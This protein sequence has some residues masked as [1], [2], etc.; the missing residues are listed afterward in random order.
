MIDSG[1][2]GVG[3]ID[4]LFAQQHDLNLK[5]LPRHIDLFGFN[6][7]RIITG[8]ITHVVPLEL[9]YEG[10]K[11][12]ISL[13]V[14]TLGKHPIIL[15]LPWMRKHEV[16]FDWVNRKLRFTAQRC[17]NHQ[18]HARLSADTLDHRSA[19][20]RKTLS[21]QRRHDDWNYSYTRALTT[22][23]P[24]PEPTPESEPEP[25][26][27]DRS[28]AAKPSRH[29][30][31]R[32]K[33]S[34]KIDSEMDIYAIGAVPLTRL[35]RKPG[36]E[37]F[38]ITIADID[39]ALAPK[40][41]TNP[42]TKLPKEYYN[43]LDV[44]SRDRSNVLPE[45]RSYDHKI[46]LEPG[47]Q[48]G[49]GPL[50]SMSQNELKVLRKYLDEHL[51][52]GFIRASSSPAAAPVIFVKKPGGGLR[53]CVDYRTLN[54]ITVK[55]RYPI[56]LIQETL[57]R[58]S[59]AKYYT[60]LDIIAAFNRLRIAKGDEWLTAFRTR[61]GLFE[62]L[63]MPFGL[64]NAPST[65]QH[66]VNDV[67]RPYL[68]VFCTAYIDDI[69]IFSDNLSEHRKHV[70][71]VLQALRE[72]GLQ[73][74]IDKCEFHKTEVL[75]LGL[76]ITTNGIR[77]DPKKVEAVTNWESPSNVKDVRAFIGFANF[78]R[79]FIS[80]FSRLAAPLV[81]LTRKDVPF[82]F[83]SACEAA[84]QALKTAFTTAPIL[85]H[86]DPELPCVVEA[87]SSDYASGGVLS[88]NGLDGKLYPVAY[89]SH[90]LSPAECNYEIYD[91]ELLAIIRCFEQWRPELEG[92]AFP[93]KVLSDH[94]N[95]QYFC[96]TKQLSHRQ[97]RWSEY[98]SRFQFSIVYRPGAQGQKP[99]AL[100]R[101][102]QDQ[103]AQ[104]EAR[105]HRRQTL[106]RPE[107]FEEL[108]PIEAQ[109][110]GN[111]E[112]SADNLQPIDR[113]I[114]QLINDE[115]ENDEF[116]Q[117]ILG[118]LRNGTRRSK[119]ISLS[120]C[121]ARDNRLYFRNRLV[122]P[123][124]DELKVKLLRYVHDSPVGGHPGRT[125]TLEIL[126]RHYYWPQMYD[127]VR[128]FVG[129][130][131]TC[132]RSKASREAYS[133][134][135]RPLPV[136]SQR[137]KDISIDFVVDLPESDGCT[138]VMVVVD[139]LTKMVHYIPCSS[140][141]APDVAQLFLT[142]VWKLHGL[143][144]TII[145]DR[146]SQFVSAFWD[147]LMKRL[148]IEARLS[149]AFHPET[150]GQTE[151]KNAIMEQYF[152][153]YTSYLQDDWAKWAPLAEFTANNTISETTGIS[154]FLANYGQHPRLGFEPPTDIVRPV[155]QKQQ[156]DNVHKFV[157]DMKNIEAFIRDEMQ[158]AQA[159]YEEKANRKRSPAPAYQIGDF[160]WLDIRNLKTRRP[161]KKLD[162][163]NIG[164]FRVDKIVSPYAYRLE[165][166]NSIKIHPVFH[167]SLLRPAT[168]NEALPGQSQEAPP[169]VEIDG[170][171]EYQV[172]RIED[173]R[174][175]RRKRCHE[176]LVRW[177]GYDESS[178][179]PAD[180]VWDTSA[181][182]LFERDRPDKAVPR[183]TL[184]T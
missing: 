159:I 17:E 149:T 179:E 124:H 157:E 58:L 122:I 78:Y 46:Q 33:H 150:D 100:T 73:L 174:F 74:D 120:E 99:D 29:G 48:P 50:Y 170:E 61:Y 76:V 154:P 62:Y 44:F 63:V 56:P 91:K 136:P 117:E 80:D 87:D 57:N 85:R 143:P 94:K 42:R 12:K 66:Y 68:D 18:E 96:T 52:K 19:K 21:P 156:V 176:Y 13:F 1:A 108:N 55:N 30:P 121:E 173:S 171:Q 184:T 45:H 162:W 107:L 163:K 25:E 20:D 82:S 8:R 119:K 141:K 37:I 168:T 32:L 167:T 106:L 102:S 158:W 40:K 71:L 140:I 89:Y 41:Y 34:S 38:A 2:T 81:R 109:P 104:E 64:A 14:T 144:D 110:Q 164:P 103:P 60:K 180:D 51:E 138:N 160:V 112:A 31:Y 35:A 90:R 115:Y 39:K 125:K 128:R 132:H 165:L 92:A 95:L 127:T 11:E 83:D 147:E 133:G 70:E 116:V 3:F 16:V 88:Q 65:F 5:R 113:S 75:Y 130:C 148:K 152:R 7:T 9:E 10:H 77:M 155:H 43:Y 49:F 114:E 169:P 4:R 177:R 183:N 22:P 98:L 178:W 161:S 175:N 93:I 86:F 6:G 134:L 84:F 151:R 69:L 139:R 135:L 59:K 126:S 123:N 145:S 105:L 182:A 166:P 97:A 172:E 118:L 137:W 129:S 142:H 181:A 54:A 36:H 15:G 47:K 26:Y 27:E 101:R 72:A 131:H 111:P 28:D 23:E 146:G 79:R 53:F 153:S 24:E 67:L